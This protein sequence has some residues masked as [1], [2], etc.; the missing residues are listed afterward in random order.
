MSRTWKFENAAGV[1][2]DLDDDITYRVLRWSQ[3]GIPALSVRS[4]P[5]PGRAGTARRSATIPGR[6]VTLFVLVQG[7]TVSD[8]ES[9]VL[10]LVNHLAGSHGRDEP[11]PGTLRVTQ[12]DGATRYLRCAAVS[13]LALN[14]AQAISPTAY[15]L[16][17]AFHADHPFWYDP[18]EQSDTGTIGQ[19]GS[20][21]FQ[22]GG[23]ELGFPVGFGP[24]DPSASVTV[25]NGGS[26]DTF[27]LL[28]KVPG[29]SVGPQLHNRTVG[30]SLRLDGL[31][32][33]AGGTLRARMGWRPDGQRSVEAMIID[34]S[35]TETDVGAATTG[36]SRA[37]WLAPGNN[38]VSFAQQNADPTVHTLKHY[39]E[40]LAI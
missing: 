19:P 36:L 7:A 2:L 26:A 20:L 27:S 28:W 11:Q 23:P 22:T 14:A 4:D 1:L 10:T 25:D 29:P 39:A 9:N 40:Y 34:S 6:A 30:R 16:P 38:A 8:L 13:G 33:P 12:H 35:G 21:R 15:G 37:V 24:D 18:T 32:V 3:T 5:L 17:V 31:T